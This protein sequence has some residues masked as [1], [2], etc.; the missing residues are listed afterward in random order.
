MVAAFVVV[1]TLWLLYSKGFLY[2][3]DAVA[4]DAS[5][6]QSFKLVDKISV[7]H[8][9]FIFR[10]ALHSPTQRLGLPIGQHIYIRSA[11]V[12]ADGK[13]EMVQHAYTPV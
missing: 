1:L 2:S 11:V 9:S 10:F 8:N 3:G 13:S 12:N 5:K 7:S 4:L 6:F